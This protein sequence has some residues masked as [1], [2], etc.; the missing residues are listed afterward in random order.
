MRDNIISHRTEALSTSRVLTLSWSELINFVRLRV[1]S[2]YVTLRLALNNVWSLVQGTSQSSLPAD[3]VLIINALAVS[4]SVDGPLLQT[5]QRLH[6]MV[7]TGIRQDFG[8]RILASVKR[9]TIQLFILSLNA[10]LRCF[11]GKISF[12]IL[13]FH[14]IRWV[15]S[16]GFSSR[17]LPKLQGGSM[18]LEG[19][20]GMRTGPVLWPQHLVSA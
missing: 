1:F 8:Q 15:I 19:L 9:K 3:P 5:Q 11:F 10:A 13:H 14:W 2:T 6:T 20:S 18:D 4:T 7:C 17:G 16:I 12:E